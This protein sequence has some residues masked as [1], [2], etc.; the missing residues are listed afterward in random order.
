[1]GQFS[2]L[3][4]P[5]SLDEYDLR[6]MSRQERW[7]TCKEILQNEPDE[8][9]R[10]DAVWLVGELAEEAGP[11]DP[12]FEKA[13]D[14]IAW[15]LKHDKN[16]IVKHEAC[17]QIAARKMHQKIP[18]LTESALND[19]SGLVAHEAIESLG[20]LNAFDSDD[21]ISS[22]I[23]SQNQD[24]RQTAEFVLKRLTRVKNKNL[25]NYF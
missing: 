19:E 11:D 5:I 14:L 9:L 13:A 16:S 12:I 15:V 7:D 25:L 20:L 10:W 24:V 3:A 8:A 1:M 23:Q 4:I 22:S 6:S 18:D 2:K 21:L 17:Y